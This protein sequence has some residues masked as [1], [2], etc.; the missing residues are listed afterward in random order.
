M[1]PE[2]RPSS[3]PRKFG[4]KG[5]RKPFHGNKN[6]PDRH[7]GDRNKPHQA[8]RDRPSFGSP[9]PS[10]EA[11]PSPID[12][13]KAKQ[14]KAH[15][16]SAQ[17][18]LQAARPSNSSSVKPKLSREE[19]RKKIRAMRIDP[20]V[21]FITVGQN[22]TWTTSLEERNSCKL[23][24]KFFTG[25]AVKKLKLSMDTRTG[26]KQQ[27]YRT[28]I[29]FDDITHFKVRLPRLSLTNPCLRH[30]RVKS[31]IHQFQSSMTDFVIT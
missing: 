26:S 16:E 4:N 11:Q 27:R 1:A 25:G 18:F 20:R 21:E 30:F 19:S 22:Q 6:G 13:K 12:E 10:K 5:D 14:I 15:N 17:K 24:A 29:N 2:R 23:S 28:E 9:R 31:K 7:V 3:G 8:G